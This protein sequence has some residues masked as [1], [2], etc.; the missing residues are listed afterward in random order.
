MTKLQKG[1]IPPCKEN[2]TTLTN[3]SLDSQLTPA[4]FPAN[5]LKAQQ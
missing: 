1:F 5:S 4:G 2:E 3:L